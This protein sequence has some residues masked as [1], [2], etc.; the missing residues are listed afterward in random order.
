LSVDRDEDQREGL[1][2]EIS[3]KAGCDVDVINLTSGNSDECQR[4]GHGANK[5]PASWSEETAGKKNK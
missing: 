4:T 2:I 3:D 5:R 1:P